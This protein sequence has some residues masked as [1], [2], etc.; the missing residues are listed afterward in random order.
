MKI[1]V[2]LRHFGENTTMSNKDITERLE[3]KFK[4]LDRSINE[5]EIVE[6]KI[7]KKNPRMN[8]EVKLPKHV[9][10]VR[11]SGK[12]KTGEEFFYMKESVDLSKA[13]D[14]LASTV[15]EDVAQKIKKKQ[16]RRKNGLSKNSHET[17]EICEA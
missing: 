7:K 5:N 13:I 2:S 16:V 9:Y 14:E 8:K 3:K 1:N 6:F 4:F 11:C 15:K 17:L 12:L 10:E